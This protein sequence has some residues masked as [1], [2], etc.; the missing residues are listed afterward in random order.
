MLLLLLGVIGFFK[1]R[2][3]YP[4]SPMVVGAILG[5]M[6]GEQL[7]K[8]MAISQG[9]ALYL[10]HSPISIVIYSA[11]VLII[12][13]GI[14]LKRRQARFEAALCDIDTATIRTVDEEIAEQLR[15]R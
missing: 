6:A 7:R 13:L 4:V 8:A 14:W 2:H 11:M 1:R 12:V 3:G 10:V 9:D 15:D 5:P